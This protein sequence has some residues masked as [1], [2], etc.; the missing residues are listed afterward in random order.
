MSIFAHLHIFAHFYTFAHLAQLF[1]F[2]TILHIL[3]QL[4]HFEQFC[5]FFTFAHFCRFCTILHPLQ[6]F[7]DFLQILHNFADLANWCRFCT[8]LL[9]L[10][11]FAYFAQFCTLCTLLHNLHN[12]AHFANSCTFCTPLSIFH[13]ICAIFTI[14][15]ILHLKAFVQLA[16]PPAF[17]ACFL[18]ASLNYCGLPIPYPHIPHINSSCLQVC[19]QI[20]HFVGNLSVCIVHFQ[21]IWG[22]GKSRP[23]I[24]QCLFLLPFFFTRASWNHR[25]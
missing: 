11:N 5:R 10:H 21:V 15:H 20:W 1:T 9:I 24:T 7:V 4:A 14:L 6:N 12:F 2:C 25:S 18:R 17:G 13:N 22:P 16:H 3:N 23:P 8:T 19:R